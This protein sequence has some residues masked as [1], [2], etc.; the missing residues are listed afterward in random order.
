[1]N[2]EYSKDVV[3]LQRVCAMLL[4][5]LQAAKKKSIDMD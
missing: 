3:I 1:M 4:E 5:L 2:V